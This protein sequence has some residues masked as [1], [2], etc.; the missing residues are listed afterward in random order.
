MEGRRQAVMGIDGGQ[1]GAVT[2]GEGGQEPGGPL[3]EW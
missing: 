2:G 1:K 3:N